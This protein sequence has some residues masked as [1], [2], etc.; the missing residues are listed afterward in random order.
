M[1]WTKE[2]PTIAGTYWSLAEASHSCGC[3]CK[4]SE[5]KIAKVKAD[6]NGNLVVLFAGV[7]ERTPIESTNGS[8]WGP[9]TPPAN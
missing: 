2:I 9:L 1:E 7:A 3:G 6:D 8:W 5:P 4:S